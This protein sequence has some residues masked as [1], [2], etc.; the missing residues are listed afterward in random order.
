MTWSSRFAEFEVYGE[1][2][3]GED[4]AEGADDDVGDAEEGVLAPRPVRRR[5]DEA[6]LAVE[7][8]DRVVVVDAELVLPR[9]QLVLVQPPPQLPAVSPQVDEWKGRV[10]GEG[11]RG[12]EGREG[13]GSPE[14]GEGGRAHPDDEVRVLEAVVVDGLGVQLPE[15]LLPGRRPLRLLQTTPS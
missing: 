3:G 10:D 15:L 12:E 4:E 7:G 1:E 9:R 11:A 5:D 8:V 6:L 14:C 2:E 13:K